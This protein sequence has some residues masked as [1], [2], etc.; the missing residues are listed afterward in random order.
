MNNFIKD[1][2]EF[3]FGKGL[4]L[5]LL[6]LGIISFVSFINERKYEG[7]AIGAVGLI[8]SA[9]YLSVHERKNKD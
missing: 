7:F 8:F 3:I 5:V 9:V 4:K 2:T 1:F 6:F